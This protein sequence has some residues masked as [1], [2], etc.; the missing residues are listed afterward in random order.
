VERLDAPVIVAQPEFEALACEVA[1]A[2]GRSLAIVTS[3]GTSAVPLPTPRP[4]NPAVVLHTSG[5]TG[6][7]SRCT[8]A[9]IGWPAESS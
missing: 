5:T 3:L 7:P 6:V 9:T 1:A 8:A 4:S 2:S